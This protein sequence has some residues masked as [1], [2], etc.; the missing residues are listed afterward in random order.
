MW[1]FEKCAVPIKRLFISKQLH[2]G[3]KHK[4]PTVNNRY[5]CRQKQKCRCSLFACLPIRPVRLTVCQYSRR[6]RY[7][8]WRHHSLLFDTDCRRY[9][10]L[11]WLYYM[12]GDCSESR[13]RKNAKES[14]RIKDS[15]FI[16]Y[17][18]F[19]NHLNEA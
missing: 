7:V 14:C 5:R 12:G 16:L 4:S 2:H 19:R 17:M 3:T 18:E 13:K 1:S 11:D 10:C 6:Y 15:S 9:P 8:S